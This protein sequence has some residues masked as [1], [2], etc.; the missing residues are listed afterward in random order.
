MSASAAGTSPSELDGWIGRLRLAPDSHRDFSIDL[1]RAEREFG[2][3]PLLAADLVAR[4]LPHAPGDD[5]PSFADMDL[6]YVGLRL[7]CATIYQGVLRRW[8]TTLAASATRVQTDIEI[9][10]TP[11]AAP[12]TDV[13]LLVARDERL[14]TRTGTRPGTISFQ[15]SIPGRWPPFDPALADLLHE[16]GE[17]DF[18]RLPESLQDDLDFARRTRLANCATAAHLLVEECTRRGVEARH[19]YGLLIAPPYSTPH[20]WSEIR[21]GDAWVPADPLLLGLLAAHGGLD[22][23]SWPPTRS[24]GGILLALAE[25]PTA[26]VRAASGPLEATFLTRVRAAS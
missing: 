4:G 12:G 19:A 7:G 23:A 15:A 21:T 20:S 10:C 17:L 16:L 14:R 18:C 25:R 3:E 2:V 1:V 24:T 26:I 22:P 8:A 5:G 6:H 9:R 13:E 11:Y